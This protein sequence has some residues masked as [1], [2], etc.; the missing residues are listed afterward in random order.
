VLGIWG[1]SDEPFKVVAPGDIRGAITVDSG[2][3]IAGVVDDAAS[4]PQVPLVC[5]VTNTATGKRVSTTTYVTPYAIDTLKYPFSDLDAMAFYPALVQATGD[6]A[7]DGHL[8]YMLTI[9]VND[10][11]NDYTIA[12]HNVWEDTYGYDA[13]YF[14]VV[15]I[16]MLL[17]QLNTDPDGTINV[18][19][20]GITVDATL[21]PAHHAARIADATTHTGRALWVGPSTI[22]VTLYPNGSATPVTQQVTVTI[23]KGMGMRGS[24]Y[25][26]PPVTNIGSEGDGWYYIMTEIEPQ[27]GPPQTLGDAVAAINDQYS[28]NQMLAVYDPVAG[29]GYLDMSWGETPWSSKATSPVITGMDEFLTGGVEKD[30]ARIRVRVMPR[31]IVAGRPVFVTGDLDNVYDVDSGTVKIYK[32]QAGQTTDTLVTEVPLKLESNDP[33]EGDGTFTFTAVV[34][35]LRHNS[36]ITAVWSGNKTYLPA[37]AW[38]VVRVHRR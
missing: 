32:R 21:G 11:T 25:V 22:D 20:T 1:S 27:T 8:D 24:L 5:N 16:Y 36:R 15:E 31:R 14:S 17:Q 19:I 28:N 38:A 12:R 2:A 13:A 30:I 3:G 26:T 4:P 6:A 23:P 33:E 34:R 7:Y 18:H 9:K 37:D 10:G 35:G 29:W